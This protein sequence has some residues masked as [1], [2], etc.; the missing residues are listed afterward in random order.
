LH[1]EE[2]KYNKIEIL[3]PE[4]CEI[5]DTFTEKEHYIEAVLFTSELFLI[6]LKDKNK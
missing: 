6:A 1:T 4:T 5:V 3:D 2:Y